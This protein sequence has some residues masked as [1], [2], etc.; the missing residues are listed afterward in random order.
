MED[1]LESIRNV[2]ERARHVRVNAERANAYALGFDHGSVAHWLSAAP[3]SFS[4]MDVPDQMR[5]VFLFNALSFC[6]WGDPKWTVFHA[7][8][9]HDGAW[10]MILALGRAVEEGVPI[11]DFG[12][13]ATMDRDTFARVLRG[14]AEIPLFEER[15]R[16]A[17]E[18]GSLMA[19]R[20]GGDVRALVSESGGEATAFVELVVGTFPS[21]A[22]RSEYDGRPVAFHKRAQLLAADL[23][24][25]FGNMSGLEHLTAC[26]DYKLPQIL[27]KLGILEIEA[28]LA[29]RI[30]RREELAHGSPEEV[31]IRACTVWAVELVRRGASSRIPRV[32]PHEINDHLWLA[33]Q[34]KYPDDKPY[35][36]TRTIAY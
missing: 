20:F 28:D 18:V 35:H 19:G 23:G 31:E 5:F 4:H 12:A 30:D 3:F 21:F 8:K 17:R 29:A 16:I 2:A 9:A 1:V 10:G 26:A 15:Y 27:R 14:S 32:R 22:D 25:L 36:R 6:Y 7:G 33:T 11:L 13:L 24:Q 34:T